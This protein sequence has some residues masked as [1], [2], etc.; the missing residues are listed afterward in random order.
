MPNAYRDRV[1]EVIDEMITQGVL[2]HSKS[3]YAA[4]LTCVVKK[5]GTI[6]VCT[7]FRALNNIIRN[8]KYVIPRI[9]YSKQHILGNVYSTIDLKNGFQQVLIHDSDRHKTAMATPWGLFEYF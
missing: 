7:D 1:K 9:D 2:R 3:H 8:D 6:R 4:P 5:D